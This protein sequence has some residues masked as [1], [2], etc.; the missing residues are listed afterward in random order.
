MPRNW[1]KT[2]P[3]GNG[4]VPQQEEF[5]SDQPRLADVYRLFEESFDR[6]LKIIKS[7]FDQEEKKS[8][9]F[10]EMRA[11]EQHSASL[12]Q[13][14]RHPRLAKVANVPSDTRTRERTE[15]AA[16]AVQAMHGYSFSANRVQAGSTCST[17][18]GIK[19]EPPAL[20][21]RDDVLV[22]KGA[23][24]PKSCLS[25]LEMSTS[26]AA[27]GLPPTDKTSTVTRTTFHQLPLWFCLTEETNSR[28]S[29]L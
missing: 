11:T 20:P 29:I 5:G 2:L 18:F 14:A 4:P 16:T 3:E 21:C 13:D 25:P 23:A 9:E 17:S 10:I 26:T 27:G 15:G 22:E 12:E 7:P 8:N 24:V 6:R 1:S 28:T 19:T